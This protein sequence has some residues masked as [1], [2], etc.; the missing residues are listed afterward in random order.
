[1]SAPSSAAETSALSHEISGQEPVVDL[2]LRSVLIGLVLVVVVNIGAPYAKYILHSSLLAC[3]Y[4]PF[5]VML[6]FIL[7]V[8]VVNPL[9]KSFRIEAGLCPGELAVVFI[10]ALV[11]LTIPTFGLTGYLI[12]TIA[13]PYYYAATENG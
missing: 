4:L 7:V 9:I 1:M 5:G 13:A 2:T 10:M 3:D 12:S 11:G 8:A 6:L